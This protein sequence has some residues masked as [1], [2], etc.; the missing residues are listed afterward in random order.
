MDIMDTARLNIKKRR[1]QK[2]L[3]QQDMAEKL[4]MTVRSYQNLESGSTR[5][6]I[7]RL[8]QVAGVLETPMEDLLKPEGYYN[9]HQEIKD[10]GNGSGVG[11]FGNEN[12]YHNN[13]ADKEIVDK[14]IAAKDG[15]NNVLKEEIKSLKEE[16]KYFRDKVDV[17]LGLIEK[18]E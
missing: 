18:K 15:E 8:E 11:Y 12:T 14:L 2:G 7:E 5:L 10:G 6:D 13:L 3:R 9:I 17:L 4:N 16:L 1:E